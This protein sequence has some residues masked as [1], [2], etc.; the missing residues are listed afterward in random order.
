MAPGERTGLPG[1]DPVD[2]RAARV[3]ELDGFES[4][5]DM[6]AVL[7]LPGDLVEDLRDRVV[8]LPR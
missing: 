4:L 7:D 3:D 5:E 6:G 1:G 8:F 2:A